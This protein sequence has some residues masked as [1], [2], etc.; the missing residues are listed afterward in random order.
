MNE[1]WGGF[2]RKWDWMVRGGLL[3]CV[4]IIKI[5]CAKVL[6]V[7]ILSLGSMLVS[8]RGGLGGRWGRFWEKVG[9]IWL[10]KT[11][12][13]SSQCPHKFGK[14]LSWKSLWVYGEV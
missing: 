10:G 9:L 7:K 1:K 11:R 2:G 6:G 8:L 13:I 14:H 12:A 4:F 5:M 3:I